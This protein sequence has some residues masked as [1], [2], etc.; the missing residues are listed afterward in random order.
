MVNSGTTAT[1][2]DLVATDVDVTCQL[3]NTVGTGA[4]SLSV[5]GREFIIWGDGTGISV[6]FG[7]KVLIPGWTNAAT[8]L[9]YRVVVQGS[10]M[11]VFANGSG[12]TFQV[13]PVPG[14]ATTVAV[15]CYNGA[16]QIDDLIVKSLT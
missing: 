1:T 9:P 16:L 7:T 6:G 12:I 11:W 5:R 15:T 8:F 10:T 13:A 4:Y 14:A 3:R 2:A